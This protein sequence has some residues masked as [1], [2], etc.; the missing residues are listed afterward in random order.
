MERSFLSI[1]TMPIP[2]VIL[3]FI[4]SGFFFY[5]LFFGLIRT[6][7]SLAGLVGGVMVAQSA[8]PVFLGWLDKINFSGS[9]PARVVLFLAIFAIAY[10]LITFL[11]VIFDRS[12]DFVSII[13]F[14]KSINKITGALFGIML[15]AV[16]CGLL[17]KAALLFP[18]VDALAVRVFKNSL[19]APLFL[20]A[21]NFALA[22]LP[23]AFAWGRGKI[24]S[25][26]KIFSTEFKRDL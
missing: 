9:A 5:G 21:G 1:I 25:F 11:F 7:G 18:R 16:L 14:F 20:K 8:F 12:F 15:G 10:R 13:P 19:M 24:D 6:I 2:D 22:F 3:L 4:V 17:I 23:G 26:V